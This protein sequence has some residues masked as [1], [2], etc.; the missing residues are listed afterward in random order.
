MAFNLL[1][2]ILFFITQDGKTPLDL[3]NEEAARA[4]TDGS[5]FNYK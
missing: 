5:K 4:F 3:A 1:V 2:D